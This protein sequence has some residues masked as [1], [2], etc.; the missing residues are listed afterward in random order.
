MVPTMTDGQVT[1]NDLL[2]VPIDEFTRGVVEA[3]GMQPQISEPERSE[4]V[5]GARLPSV[6]RDAAI[7][8]YMVD[9]GRLAEA[10]R[11][12]THL[13]YRR[14]RDILWMVRRL[15][16]V[17]RA[18]EMVTSFLGY[19]AGWIV[20]RAVVER[21][22]HF[23]VMCSFRRRRLAPNLDAL[24]AEGPIVWADRC[25]GYTGGQPCECPKSPLWRPA[26]LRWM[27]RLRFWACPIGHWDRGTQV[28]DPPGDGVTVMPHSA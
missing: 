19:H 24:A 28:P 9:Q 2:P 17:I 23:C 18:Y 5:S 21:R 26:S 12:R 7:Q 20:R 8:R 10:D 25:Y 6:V 22:S 15:E 4:M 14:R 1:G 27:I 16:M 3:Y 13:R 11:R